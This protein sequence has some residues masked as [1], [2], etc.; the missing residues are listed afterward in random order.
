MSHSGVD[1]RPLVPATPKEKAPIEGAN[2]GLMLEIEFN[3]A[4]RR[5]QWGVSDDVDNQSSL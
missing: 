3:G 1:S 2:A 5:L 4:V